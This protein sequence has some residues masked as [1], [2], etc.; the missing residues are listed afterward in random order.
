VRLP[1][2]LE[3]MNSSSPKKLTRSSNDKMV[4]GVAAGL[5]DYFGIDPVIARV[6]FVVAT[7][8]TGVAAIAYLAMMIVVPSDDDV[9]SDVG[10]PLPV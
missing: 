10:E 2:N 8:T 7:L 6:A 1:G 3:R 4:G 9:S 5:A